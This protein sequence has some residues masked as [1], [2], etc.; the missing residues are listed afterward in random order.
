MDTLLMVAVIVTALAFIVQAGALVAIY[1]LSRRLADNANSLMAESR[2]F[3][4][5]L[6]SIT[7]DLKA[8][9]DDLAAVAKN[10]REQVH[11]AN[12]AL[13]E[14]VGEAR[15]TVMR[16]LRQWSAFARGVAEGVRTFFGK[17]RRPVPREQYR[18]PT[19]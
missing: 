5:P 13:D 12:K 19:A 4:G 14:T 7:G 1:L 17:T 15:K 16:P 6:E 3:V 8:A 2:R 18:Y 11:R 9:S 10:A